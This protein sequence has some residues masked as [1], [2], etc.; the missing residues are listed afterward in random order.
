[1]I[2]GTSRTDMEKCVVY[3]RWRDKCEI[4]CRLGL[5]SVEGPYSLALMNEADHYYQQYK[6]A[7]EYDEIL[8]EGG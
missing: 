6:A 4:K 1:M 8:K 5:W 7:G 3:R 2:S